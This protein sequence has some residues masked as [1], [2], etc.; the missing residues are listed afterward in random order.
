MGRRRAASLANFVDRIQRLTGVET[1]G[2]VTIP[3][4]DTNLHIQSLAYV[5]CK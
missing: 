4:S 2:V 1:S 3:S 5:K